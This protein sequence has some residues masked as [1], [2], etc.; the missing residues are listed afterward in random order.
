MPALSAHGAAASAPELLRAAPKRPTAKGYGGQPRQLTTAEALGRIEGC[1]GRLGEA[2]P[3]EK[4]YLQ[5]CRAPPPRKTAVSRRR[6]AR[7]ATCSGFR[8]S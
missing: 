1:L 3:T 4:A 5:G 6:W 7:A 2:N 8:P